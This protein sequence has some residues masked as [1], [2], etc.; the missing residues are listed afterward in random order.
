MLSD[1]GSDTPLVDGTLDTDQDMCVDRDERGE[2]DSGG[3]AG[4][5][6]SESTDTCRVDAA[7]RPTVGE[8]RA[9]R[10]R[11]ARVGG[12]RRQGEVTTET[13]QDP[14]ESR[15]EPPPPLSHLR[16]AQAREARAGP[17]DGMET[18]SGDG[19]DTESDSG[20]DTTEGHEDP[21][22]TEEENILLETVKQKVEH[23]GCTPFVVELMK[24]RERNNVFHRIVLDRRETDVPKLY[25]FSNDV[26]LTCDTGI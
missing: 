17:D 6:V 11:S 16:S 15:S 5:L 25:F 20:G 19:S 2:N 24:K 8:P 4:V 22:D 3:A 14:R 23:S 18:V 9:L 7:F 26:V 12:G 21:A 1:I 13:V 10:P